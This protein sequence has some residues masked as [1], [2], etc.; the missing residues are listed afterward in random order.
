[1]KNKT[2]NEQRLIV[3]GPSKGFESIKKIDENE[4]EYWTARSLYNFSVIP[5]GAPLTKSP[6]EPLDPR[7]I[8]I[9][10]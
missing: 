4:V 8:A 10:T 7:G 3:M 2:K 5:S 9:R 1:M 6:H